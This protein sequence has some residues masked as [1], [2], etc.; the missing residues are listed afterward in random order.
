MMRILQVAAL[1]AVLGAPAL[2]SAAQIQ[3]VFD[4]VDGVATS[5]WYGTDGNAAQTSFGGSNSG[6]EASNRAFLTVYNQNQGW[7]VALYRANL[8]ADFAGATVNSA[9]F[10]VRDAFFNGG[11]ITNVDLNRV[12]LP[13]N[14]NWDPG[15]GT[16]A[17]RFTTPDNGAQRFWADFDVATDTGL[18]WAGNVVSGP[19]NGG[20]STDFQTSAMGQVIDTESFVEPAGSNVTWDVLTLAQNWANGTWANDGFALTT[21]NSTGTVGYQLQTTGTGRGLI[22]D[23]TPI[24]EP[25]SLGLLA[26]AGLFL[27]GRRKHCA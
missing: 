17:D 5:L 21:F 24:P 16:N 10:T 13:G 11:S 6:G 20:S 2:A 22:I 8:P 27:L 26:V 19:W 7:G 18:D 3:I 9:T 15:T 4:D 25:A 14:V 23:Y 12:N 1:G